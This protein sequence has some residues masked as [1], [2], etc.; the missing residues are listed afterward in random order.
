MPPSE[1]PQGASPAGNQGYSLSILDVLQS[2]DSADNAGL[3]Q[4]AAYA[5]AKDSEL[6]QQMWEGD[7]RAFESIYSRYLERLTRCAAPYLRSLDLAKDVAQETFMRLLNNPPATLP[8]DGLAPW[9]FSVAKHLAIDRAKH[10]KFEIP[11]ESEQP[12]ISQDPREDADPADLVVA[13]SN[14]E[15]V[16]REVARLPEE[17]RKVIRLHFE[18]NLTFQEIADQEKVPLGTV[19]WRGHRALE[20]LR[21]RL[22]ELHN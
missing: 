21:G 20:V 16:Q 19:L 12:G 17:L 22:R 3:L 13:S 8:A 6:F 11:T 7:I 9:L 10:L 18:R 1:T 14:A 2:S 4:L 5:E 15:Q